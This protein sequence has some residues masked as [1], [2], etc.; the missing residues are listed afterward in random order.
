MAIIAQ[1]CSPFAGPVDKSISDSYYYSKSKKEIRYSPMGNWFSLG[2]TNL[3]ADVKSFKV[4]G[5]DF[6]K[7]KNHLYFRTNIIDNEVD[8]ATFYVHE[9]DYTC[10]DKDHVYIAI[11]YMP[12]EIDKINQEKKHLWKVAK[13]NPK[14]FQ[15]IDQD[16]AKD[17][18]HYF[19]NYVPVN[20]DYDSFKVLNKSFAKDKNQVYL[21]KSYELL[22]ATTIDPTTSK[23]INDRYIV[24][25]N[26]VHDFQEYKNGKKVDSLTSIP[27]QNIDNLVILDDKY[28]LFDSNVI[29][30]GVKIENAD[31]SSF[32]V[33]QFHYAKDKNHVFYFGEVIEGADPETFSIFETSYYS[34]DKNHVFAYGKL[35]KEA[36]VATFGPSNK[37]HSLLYQDKNH[38]YRGDEIVE[39]K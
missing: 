26:G 5:R 8:V 29:Y 10:F 35:L 25:K 32:N 17:D 18:K 12:Q 33:I 1:A 39:D 6:G 31:V 23:K 30:D 27:Y 34:K 14:T 19:Y 36:D 2:N 4:L 24:D 20:V 16:W 15:K 3:N 22:V 13:A 38:T 7:D 37:K 21:L 9:D 28:L 11:N